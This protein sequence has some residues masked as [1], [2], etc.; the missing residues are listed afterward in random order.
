MKKLMNVTK[1]ILKY[2]GTIAL[3]GFACGVG[4]L[5]FIDGAFI[6]FRNEV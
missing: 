1:R 6:I 5:C 4:V 2:V 3:G